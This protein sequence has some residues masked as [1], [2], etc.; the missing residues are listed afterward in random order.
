MRPE[1]SILQFAS[2]PLT[3]QL[4]VSLLKEYKRPNDKINEWL[5]QGQL[6]ALKRGLYVWNSS[7]L[8][9]LFSIAN[10]LSAP[11]YVSAES[12]LSFRGLIP[13][14]VFTII[15]MSFI[16]AKNFQNSLGNFEYKKIPIPYYSFGIAREELS[17][18]QF[19]LVAT[20]EKAV[21]DKVI[22]TSGTV[23]R[24]VAAAQTYLLDN[25]RIAEEQLKLLDVEK[26]KSWLPDS[27]KK[28]SIQHII[29]AIETL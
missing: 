4:L 11:S 17:P 15:S 7:Q 23:L 6:I 29:K 13:E 5:K 26:M 24:S 8:P 22:S 20:A 18:K 9:E 21:L 3:H 25:L 16:S 1:E 19:A 28:E 2:Q 27:P 12:A 10:V 14:R